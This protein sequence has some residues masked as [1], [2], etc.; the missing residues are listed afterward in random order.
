MGDI[1]SSARFGLAHAPALARRLREA[2]EAEQFVVHYLPKI[3]LATG[4]VCGLEALLRWEDPKRGLVGPDAFMPV[5]EETDLILEVGDWTIRHALSQR[6]AWH[7]AG[8]RPPRVS[9][10]VSRSQLRQPGFV[11][12]ICDSLGTVG[13]GAPGLEIELPESLLEGLNGDGDKLRHGR[14][15]RGH[16]HRRLRGGPRLDRAPRRPADK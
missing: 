5:L 6:L 13:V 12:T 14:P 15:G 8:L 9:V 1:Q 7:I 11:R 3:D 2:M 4:A 10:N 16:R